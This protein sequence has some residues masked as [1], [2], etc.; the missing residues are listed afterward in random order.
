MAQKFQSPE[1]YDVGQQLTASRLNNMVNGAIPLPPII[2]DLPNIDTGTVSSDDSVMVYDA[3]EVL[4]REAKVSDILGSSLPITASTIN[5]SSTSD[6]T[7]L[8]VD[9]ALVSGKAYNSPDSLT[10]VVTSTAHELQPGQ[11][12]EV[13]SATNSA[14]NGTYRIVSK[15]TDTFTYVL[16]STTY[17]TTGTFSNTGSTLVTVVTQSPHGLTTGQQISV[18]T[19]NS[20]F[21]GIRTI[22]VVNTTTF[23]YTLSAAFGNGSGTYTTNDSY[24]YTV[25]S[26]TSVN[27]SYGQQMTFTDTANSISVL[28]EVGNSYGSNTFLFTPRNRIPVNKVDATA[29]FSNFSL[30]IT[31]TK[32]AHGLSTGQSIIVNRPTTGLSNYIAGTYTITVIDANTF[33]YTKTAYYGGTYSQSA[34]PMYYVKN[35]TYT[36]TFTFVV[37]G[38]YSNTMIYAVSPLSATGTL[39]YTKKALL[40]NKENESISKNLYVDGVTSLNG[41]VRVAGSQ[42]NNG[43]VT[44]NGTTTV[45]GA[46]NINGALQKNGVTL[47][48][49]YSIDSATVESTT[50]TTANGA[51]TTLLWSKTTGTS[52]WNTTLTVPTGE[53]WEIDLDAYFIHSGTQSA[54][55]ALTR[56][57]SSVVNIIRETNSPISL[58][59]N[60]PVYFNAKGVL[61]AGTHTI[62]LKSYFYG[63]ANGNIS[64]P[65]NNS[66]SYILRKYKIA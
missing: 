65:Y 28:G 29:A 48:G 16:P 66:S 17:P 58:V 19:E 18:T 47:Y 30:T 44:L 64:V 9:G 39:D 43:A 20:T 46:L 60:R 3:S 34:Y 53:I 55:Y 52:N 41:A 26:A 12:V 33:T 32:T 4:L 45:N 50:S 37:N 36:G 40:N 35:Q 51:V 57:T 8:P 59:A 21:N 38:T 2:T 7:V 24:T 31:V 5:G 1:N 54:Y 15:T 62:D 22:T 63:T 25:V 11:V 61:P 49:L 56:T 14:F 42:T 10:N 27:L 23:T 13:T 6:I